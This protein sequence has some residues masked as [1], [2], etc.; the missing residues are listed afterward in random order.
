MTISVYPRYVGP[1]VE[2]R[3]ASLYPRW[4]NNIIGGVVPPEVE[5]WLGGVLVL[6][7]Q[8]A[9]AAVGSALTSLA[10]PALL[11]AISLR[12]ALDAISK[13]S[14]FNASSVGG[15]HDV[16]TLAGKITTFCAT[17]ISGVI[18]TTPIAD[19]AEKNQFEAEISDEE[20]KI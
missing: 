3:Y 6:D 7:E 15:G 18:E 14:E 5:E 1:T 2:Y 11:D 19:V 12:P 16:K 8:Y 13:A 4:L 17:V 9:V 20:P 10:L